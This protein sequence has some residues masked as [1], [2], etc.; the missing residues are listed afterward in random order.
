MANRNTKQR[1]AIYRK[2][3]KA[4]G[5]FEKPV[6][7]KKSKPFPETGNSMTLAEQRK[8]YYGNQSN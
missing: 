1:K 3:A 5:G 4:N 7:K 8:M 6:Y 2:Y